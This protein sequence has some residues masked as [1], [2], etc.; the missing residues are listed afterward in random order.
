LHK[1]RSLGIPDTVIIAFCATLY[2]RL[3][4]LND[5]ASHAEDGTP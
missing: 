4:S 3:P 1:S 2:F 5:I